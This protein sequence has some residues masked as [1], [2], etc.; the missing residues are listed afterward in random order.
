MCRSQDE[1]FVV[2][3]RISDIVASFATSPASSLMLPTPFRG[4]AQ[5]ADPLQNLTWMLFGYDP[6]EDAYTGGHSGTYEYRQPSGE[7]HEE[8]GH[9]HKFLKAW[10]ANRGPTTSRC[11][12]NSQCEPRCLRNV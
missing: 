7:M 9:I 8:A 2:M 3:A 1:P 6:K 11:P 10:P 12:M 4:R 5:G